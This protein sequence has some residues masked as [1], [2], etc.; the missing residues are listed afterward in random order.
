MRQAQAGLVDGR[1]A[2]EQA[3]RA[4]HAAGASAEELVDGLGVSAAAVNRILSGT[5]TRILGGRGGDLLACSF[6]GRSQKEV[7]RLVAGP[8]VYIC[9][10]CILSA[11]EVTSTGRAHVGRTGSGPVM[12]T[13]LAGDCSFCGKDRV[14]VDDLVSCVTEHAICSECLEICLEVL[15]VTS[16]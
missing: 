12:G 6:C 4:L 2:F 5:G 10:D 8:V 3:L 13:S 7:R 1:E 11:Q 16:A 15:D 14:E 9:N